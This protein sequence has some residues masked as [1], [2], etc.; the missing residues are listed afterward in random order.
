MEM[1]Q[2]RMRSLKGGRVNCIW[3]LENGVIPE[4]RRSVM[5]VPLYMG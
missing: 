2:V 1:L 3:R 4:D 5:I